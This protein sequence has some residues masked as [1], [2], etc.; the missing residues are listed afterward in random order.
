M[1]HLGEPL[2]SR[3]DILETIATSCRREK[4]AWLRGHTPIAVWPHAG[5]VTLGKFLKLS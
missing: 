2:S 1:T 3:E 4:R 5:W